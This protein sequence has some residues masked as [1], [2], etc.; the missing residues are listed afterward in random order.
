MKFPAV[1]HRIR[2]DPRVPRSAGGKP[3]NQ[4]LSAHD[5]AAALTQ[6]PRGP[7]LLCRIKYADDWTGFRDLLA[8]V[9]RRVHTFAERKRW[10]QRHPEWFERMAL[11][12]LEE[13]ELRPRLC[14]RCKGRRE[15]RPRK[16]KPRWS[17]CPACEGTGKRRLTEHQRAN[18]AGIPW[19]SWRRTWRARQ[20]L[21]KA[22]LVLWEW[23]AVRQ[24]LRQMRRIE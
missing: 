24:L 8:V 5:I 7:A 20:D 14:E 12:A 1:W 9:T 11:L 21:V 2:A 16:P 19:E 4:V 17:E 22:E 6:L 13:A 3:A 23:M 18:S 15:V 10:N